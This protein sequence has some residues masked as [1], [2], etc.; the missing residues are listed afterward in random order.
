MGGYKKEVKHLRETVLSSDS[1]LR[2][3]NQEFGKLLREKDAELARK[4]GELKTLK[5]AE[6]TRE[7]ENQSDREGDSGPATEGGSDGKSALEELTAL[8]SKVEAYAKSV[9]DIKASKQALQEQHR[10]AVE[11]V[12]AQHKE[13]I[14]HLQSMIEAKAEALKAHESSSDKAVTRLSKRESAL[15]TEVRHLTM[16]RKTDEGKL[17]DNQALVR[18]LREKKQAA[19]RLLMEERTKVA[20]AKTRTME[21]SVKLLETL[22]QTSET[23]ARLDE[24]EEK[25]R[26]CMEE[27]EELKAA[28]GRAQSDLEQTRRTLAA[29]TAQCTKL[30]ADYKQQGEELKQS[31]LRLRSALQSSEADT[32]Q[33]LQL[34]QQQLEQQMAETQGKVEAVLA[35]QQRVEELET[36]VTTLHRVNKAQEDQLTHN[37]AEMESMVKNL[38]DVSANAADASK[39]QSLLQDVQ[40]RAASE[41]SRLSDRVNAL[42]DELHA[43]TKMKQKLEAEKDHLAEEQAALSLA[44]VQSKE[45]LAEGET[46]AQQLESEIAA[47]KASLAAQHGQ[48]QEEQERRHAQALE[49]QE[50]R[51]A[52]QAEALVQTQG[53]EWQRKVEA[54]HAEKL[55]ELQ[56]METE[57]TAK[58]QTEIARL[59]DDLTKDSNN[60]RAQL[61]TLGE[62]MKK[63]I[64]SEAQRKVD[65]VGGQLKECQLKLQQAR[66]DVARSQREHRDLLDTHQK[67]KKTQSVV[68]NVL[69]HIADTHKLSVPAPSRKTLS[70]Q[71]VSEVCGVLSTREQQSSQQMQNLQRELQSVETQ[72]KHAMQ[73]ASQQYDAVLTQ[74]KKL[75]GDCRDAFQRE[76]VARSKAA[77]LE[78]ECT[79][80][81]DEQRHQERSLK[82]DNS[83]LFEENVD[84]KRE[85]GK[86]EAIIERLNK[87][88]EE[89]V[90]D[91]LRRDGEYERK[92]VVVNRKLKSAEQE[93]ERLRHQLRDTAEGSWTQHEEQERILEQ[94]RKQNQQY[95]LDAA[96]MD[97]LAEDYQDLQRAHHQKSS[98]CEENAIA[99]TNLQ[100]VL[101]QF[102]TEATEERLRHEQ[103]VAEK[104]ILIDQGVVALKEGPVLK[105]RLADSEST[106]VTV[107]QQLISSQ[108]Y[109]L[110]LENENAVMREEFESKVK[111]LRTF[112]SSEHSVD[113]RLVVKMIVTYFERP[114]KKEVLDLMVKMFQFTAK[115][116][117]RL[118][119]GHARSTL[120]GTLRSF[121]SYLNPIDDSI[122]AY[123]PENDENLADTFVDYLLQES[124]KQILERDI[125]AETKGELPF[126]RPAGPPKYPGMGIMSTQSQHNHRNHN[127]N[128]NQNQHPNQN[129]NQSQNENHGKHGNSSGEKDDNDEGRN[130]RSLSLSS[131][132]S[133]RGPGEAAVRLPLSNSASNDSLASGS[134]DKSAGD[135]EVD[136]A[137]VSRNSNDVAAAVDSKDAAEQKSGS[138]S[139]GNH[140]F[141]S[142][143]ISSDLANEFSGSSN[144]DDIINNAD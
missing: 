3:L 65:A 111:K 24:S 132:D 25:N 138:E 94:L 121:A 113:R 31:G 79:K 106:L 129:H 61:K 69:L 2:E 72:K 85:S 99:Y 105:E 14:T 45:A 140:H 134:G 74:L 50:E 80:L 15:E 75:Q 51:H 53:E 125:K 41:R 11:Q 141:S 6:N 60:M 48:Q 34:L 84:L 52:R 103:V 86:H 76:E 67:L 28:A 10:F 29:K 43:C 70:P 58:K 119:Q 55:Q 64:H 19:E 127:Q 143:T 49:E 112:S 44:Y 12:N 88:M 78:V 23:R 7:N 133:T 117:D 37:R 27:I 33:K 18:Q 114:Q 77:R 110:K 128:H 89:R 54:V 104:D 13:Q 9:Q 26:A 39:T 8:R 82:G 35:A 142:D 95:Q 90:A 73:Q 56:R 124:E 36:T 123:I 115:E 32:D 131:V 4:V 20:K 57:Y 109:V 108:K 118:Y 98:E 81:R 40:D 93:I 87:D 5:G 101:E 116:Q 1:Q 122:E 68:L 97:S 47:L 137:N 38:V 102:Q 107:R 120:G 100:A 30:E 46:R 135:D 71:F 62:E 126:R 92:I 42:T 136:S 130:S 21:D 96:A 83:A 139:T 66:E 63:E 17:R 22:K 144:V 91:Q 16:Q 59:R